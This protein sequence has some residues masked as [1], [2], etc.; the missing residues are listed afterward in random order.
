MH[1]PSSRRPFKPVRS[2]DSQAR[3]TAARSMTQ[4]ACFVQPESRLR[5]ALL[6]KE[7]ASY[8]R[9]LRSRADLTLVWVIYTDLHDV[10][11]KYRDEE[12]SPSDEDKVFRSTSFANTASAEAVRHFLL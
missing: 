12:P 10:A 7:A 2:H 1:S 9:K 8:T 4:I 11:A 3:T 6:E 5:F